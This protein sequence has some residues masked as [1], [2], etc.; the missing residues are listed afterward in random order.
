MSRTFNIQHSTFNFQSLLSH[1]RSALKVK[2][3][4][5]S[6]SSLLLF[7]CLGGGFAAGLFAGEPSDFQINTEKTDATTNFAATPDSQPASSSRTL[8]ES[9]LLEL[10]TTTL[11]RDYVKDRGELELHLSRPWV[12]RSIPDEPLTLKV[13]D[14]PPTG[15]TASFILRFELRTSRESLGT[16]QIAAQARVWKNIWVASSY[17]KRGEL[18]ADAEIEQQRRDVLTLHDS[19]A[20]FVAGDTSL[21]LAEPLPPGSPLLAR[22]VKAR[23]VV[24]RG[25]AVDALVQ[26]GM[27][28]ISMKVE[29]LEDG[30]PGQVVRARNSQSRRD[31]RG[32]V[33]DEKTILVSL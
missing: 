1:V 20:D 27:L 6:V 5:L 8:T 4:M 16:W 22:S 18:V 9:D 26:D 19:L 30:A 24:H 7:A 25:Q 14:L 33:L 23:P 28:S 32:K 12:S 21:E 11:Q 2:R 10:L 29:V 15:V 13:L 3:W 31:L 17:L